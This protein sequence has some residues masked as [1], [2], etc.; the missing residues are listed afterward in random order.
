[1]IAP[2][3]ALF[4]QLRR[5]GD[6]LMCTPSIRA[7]K[8]R[9]PDCQ[10]DF[11]TEFPDVLLG[12]SN[13]DKV[14]A[15]DQNRE[16]NFFYQF[17]LIRKI[18]SANY[19]LIVDFLS[20]PRSAYYSY[21]SGAKVRLSY[22][23]GHRR[24]A[25][26]LVPKKSDEAV[27]SALD[28]LRLLEAIDI[29]QDGLKLEFYPGDKDRELA[30]NLVKT[31]DEKPLVTLSPVSR[32]KFNRW[33]L[34]NYARLAELLETKLNA[35]V[36]AITGPGEDDIAQRVIELSNAKIQDQQIENLGVLGAIFERVS[37]HIGN[38]NGPKHIAVACGA[39]TITIYGPHSPISWT[40]PEPSRHDYVSPPNLCEDCKR[41]KHRCDPECINSISVESVWQKVEKMARILPGFRSVPR[42]S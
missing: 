28:K 31:D 17:E 24:W 4:I 42:R 14:I 39:P 12:N 27:Y 35:T 41:R 21:L 19:D 11:L 29:T 25:Y 20:G 22:G 37:L 8:K 9:Y 38:D 1:M 6:I 16:F 32:R 7:F 15:V 10:L 26:N 23:I 2:R 5:I 13:I 34:E 40:Y 33:P 30:A 18:R 36:M 3:K